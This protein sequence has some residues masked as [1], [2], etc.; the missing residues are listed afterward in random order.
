MKNI[1]QGVCV[2]LFV[3]IAVLGVLCIQHSDAQGT[4]PAGGS[5]VAVCNLTQLFKDYK[6]A[7][8]LNEELNARKNSINSEITARRAAIDKIAAQ[9]KGLKPGSEQYRLK[10]NQIKK[11]VI[12]LEVWKRVN[13]E[14][15]L[16]D[17]LRLTGEM[18]GKI[19]DATKVVAEKKGLSL[20]L[21]LEPRDLRAGNTQELI[22]QLLNRKTL[23]YSESLDIT[24]DV[25]R[26]INED[27]VAQ[28]PEGLKFD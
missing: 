18:F 7:Q 6:W 13:E 27:Y 8:K 19:S 1:K 3:V 23:Y 11:Q 5:K 15:L 25:L 2:A 24:G 14:D 4:V 22:A 21:Q 17:H 28:P 9:C 20:V 26:K 16:Q 12:D 10:Q